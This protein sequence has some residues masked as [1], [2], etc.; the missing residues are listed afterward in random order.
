M[1][2]ALSD[3]GMVSIDSLDSDD[4]ALIG[5]PNKVPDPLTDDQPVVAELKDISSARDSFVVGD[6]D[7]AQ[8]TS[9]L[10]HVA[11]S[12]AEFASANVDALLHTPAIETAPAAGHPAPMTDLEPYPAVFDVTTLD[13]TNGFVLDFHFQNSL[14]NADLNGDGFSDIISGGANHDYGATGSFRDLVVYGKAGAFPAELTSSIADGVNGFAMVGRGNESAGSFSPSSS[15]IGDFNGDGYDDAIIE[16]ESGAFGVN[17]YIAFGRSTFGAI[18]NVTQGSGITAFQIDTPATHSVT[19]TAAGDVNGDGFADVIIGHYFNDHS[20]QTNYVVFGHSG[21]FPPLFDVWT[22]DGTDGFTMTGTPGLGGDR[23]GF[24]IASAGDVNGD[25]ISDIIMGAYGDN[26]F[27]GGA[28]V[29]FGH[30]GSFSPNVDLTALNGTDGFKLSGVSTGDY[31]GRAVASVG[32]FNGD[33]FSDLAIT[34]G[35]S[36]ATESAY[37]V[38]GH[39]GSFS[40]NFDLSTLDGTNGSSSRAPAWSPRPETS[41]ATASVTLSSEIRAPRA[42]WPAMPMW[43][44]GRPAAFLRPSTC[45]R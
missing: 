2:Q 43:F 6:P 24:A 18:D 32:D 12:A 29:V 16:G 36:F 22:V 21:S 5:R 23:D 40:S 45:P 17:A 26:S 34:S 38:F 15:G 42:I 30:T 9:R 11:V 25:G 7:F 14:S 13:G 37:I 33:G 31:T 39:G 41:M 28:Y 8:F 19:V 10:D 1:S 4:I 44:S 3:F 20:D 27:T 35:N